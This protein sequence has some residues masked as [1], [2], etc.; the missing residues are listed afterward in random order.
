[1]TLTTYKWTTETYH[2][3]IDSGIFDGEAVELLR[4]EIIV[5]PP[6]RE[7]HAYYNSEVGDYLR[8]LL[9]NQVKI[10]DAKPITL[11]NNSEPEP[12]LAIVK[13]LGKEY[14]THHPYPED[15]FWI[16]EF[17]QATLSKDLREKKDIYAEAGI[18]EYWVV[19]LKNFHLKVFRNLVNQNYQSELTLK[20]G[21]IS[22]LSFPQINIEVEKIIT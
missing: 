15:I 5:M 12:D 20:T 11:P 19:D 22:P 3:A 10:R 14:L 7:P 17:A 4:G 13:P 2:Q 16:I 8:N 9:G 18:K 1:M 6:E 21:Q